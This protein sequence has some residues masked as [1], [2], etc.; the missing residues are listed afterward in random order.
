MAC[1]LANSDEVKIALDEDEVYLIWILLTNLNSTWYIY[2][3]FSIY[4][5]NKIT[6]IKHFNNVSTS[7]TYTKWMDLSRKT[8]SEE[9]NMRLFE[10]II[11]WFLTKMSYFISQKVGNPVQIIKYVELS[12]CQ[13][14]FKTFK[15][16]LL[17]VYS[18]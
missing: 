8:S 1:L 15:S 4:I 5:S 7:C 16:L 14:I 12:R 11:Y 9:K 2:F 18:L 3:S 17:N 6:L 10:I 13:P